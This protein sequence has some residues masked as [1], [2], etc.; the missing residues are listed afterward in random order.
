MNMMP[1][2]CQL[3]NEGVNDFAIR[4]LLVVICSAKIWIVDSSFEQAADGGSSAILVGWGFF[5]WVMV[6]PPPAWS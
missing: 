5:F 6:T 1:S 4:W 3:R 2:Q